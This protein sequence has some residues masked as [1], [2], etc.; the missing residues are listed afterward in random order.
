MFFFS[1]FLR[2]VRVYAFFP[3]WVKLSRLP[4]EKKESQM[5]YSRN[6]PYHKFQ[7]DLLGG[8]GLCVCVCVR[9]RARARER[10]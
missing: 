7:N 6:G 4:K 2:F 8:C 5:G 3:W 10:A 9:A 1:F